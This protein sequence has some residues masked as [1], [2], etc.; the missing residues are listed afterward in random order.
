MHTLAEQAGQAEHIWPNHSQ[1]YIQRLNKAGFK[2]PRSG[3]D[4][5]IT[6]HR[7]TSHHTT[8]HQTSVSHESHHYCCHHQH[9]RHHRHPTPTTHLPPF[10]IVLHLPFAAEPAAAPTAHLF[11]SSSSSH[12]ATLY[13]SW[14]YHAASSS[15]DRESCTIKA[16]L[17]SHDR[18]QASYTRDWTSKEGGGGSVV[19]MRDFETQPS[20]ILEQKKTQKMLSFVCTIVT[21]NPPLTSFWQHDMTR[22]DMT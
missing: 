17:C 20:L 18:P 7:M 2:T 1:T 8:P 21:F 12:G 22:H 5:I 6:S 16:G 13:P 3:Q 14:V 10:L 19:T 15:N 9:H 4:H 11:R